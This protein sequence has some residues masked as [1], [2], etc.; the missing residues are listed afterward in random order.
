[1]QELNACE[2]CDGH[3]KTQQAV[4]KQQLTT[5]FIYISL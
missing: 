2:V 4:Q 1:M 5:S 3:W